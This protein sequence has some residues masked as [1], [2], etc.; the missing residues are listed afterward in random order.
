MAEY[1][2]SHFNTL[3]MQ[4]L[5]RIGD[6][7]LPGSGQLPAFSTT[8]CLHHLDVVLDEVD[9]SDVRLMAVLLLAL[10]FVPAFLLSYLLTLMDR[11]DRYPEW[12]AGPLRLIS[13]ALKG[14]VMSLYFS[15][16]SVGEADAAGVHRAMQYQLHC[17]PDSSRSGAAAT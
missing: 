10:R 1:V 17:E 15:G 13:L 8:G 7:Y 9:P 11:H 2:S 12:L 6:L 16:L 3:Q 4:S 5:S 14:V